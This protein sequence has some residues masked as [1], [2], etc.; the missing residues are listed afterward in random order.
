MLEQPRQNPVPETSSVP[1]NIP[2]EQQD[3]FREVLL[4]LERTKI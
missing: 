4:L 3:L 1:L 2:K